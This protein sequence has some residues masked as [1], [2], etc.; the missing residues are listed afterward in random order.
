MELGVFGLNAKAPL[1]PGHTA[2]LARRAEELG[3]DSWWAGE[4][5]VLPS[6]RTPG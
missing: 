1:A 3:Y 5:V 4:H 2:R 6:P